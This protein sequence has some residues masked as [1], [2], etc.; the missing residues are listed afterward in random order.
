M[1]HLWVSPCLQQLKPHDNAQYHHI[2]LFFRN[3]LAHFKVVLQVAFFISPVGS[4]H[5]G[6]QISKRMVWIPIIA[7]HTNFWK[8][9]Y[10]CGTRYADFIGF[11]PKPHL[12]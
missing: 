8:F 12:K 3:P 6:I 10:P 11:S 7:I 9:E 5:M 1:E 4:L 2:K